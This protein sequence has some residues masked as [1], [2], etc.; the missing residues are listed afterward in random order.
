MVFL[1]LEWIGFILLILL[2]IVYFVWAIQKLFSF[3]DSIV[4]DWITILTSQRDSLSSYLVNAFVIVSI[5]TFV[6]INNPLIADNKN[7]KEIIL[8]NV[9]DVSV[10]D[11]LIINNRAEGEYLKLLKKSLKW[12]KSTLSSD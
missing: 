10:L 5:A 2:I 3:D 8:V 1:A 6:R 7:Q 11:S 12:R 9:K 4:Y